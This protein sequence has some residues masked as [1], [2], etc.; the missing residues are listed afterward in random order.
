MEMLAGM[1]GT[2]VVVQQHPEQADEILT[3]RLLKVRENIQRTLDGIKQVGEA[4]P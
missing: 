1:S 2:S 4:R 3:G